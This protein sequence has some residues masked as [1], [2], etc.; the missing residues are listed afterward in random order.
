MK[1]LGIIGLG[2]I[3]SNIATHLV[4][5]NH[6]LAVYDCDEQKRNR[7]SGKALVCNNA[8]E[9]LQNSDVVLLSLP[10]S[11][12][13]ESVMEE[14]FASGIQNKVVI[15]LSTSFP[16]STKALYKRCKEL[17]AEFI[18]CP[19]LAG[20]DEAATGELIAVVSGTKEIIGQLDDVFLSFCKSYDYVGESGNAHTMKI[21]MNFTGL[22]YVII[23]GQM[24][25]LA[26]K[27]GLDPMNL[28]H[29][30]DNEVFSTWMYRFY[31]P[32]MI[33]RTFDKAFDLKLGLKDLTY[34]K[35]LYDSYNVPA[36]TLDGALDLLRI[37]MKEG[38]GDLD[39]SRC[40]EIVQEFLKL[41][42]KEEN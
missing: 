29:V 4:N 31:G 34:M 26:E 1:K 35:K 38:K 37:A 18:D 39:F 30:M 41:P 19:L 40:A 27:V 8:G 24:F 16:L 22:M 13:V 42:G 23:L 14:L 28:Y 33:N 3:G 17:G 5:T 9:V 6:T 36:F 12:I 25:P 32:K 10:T 21:M 15:D 7:F 20:P 2:L 11:E